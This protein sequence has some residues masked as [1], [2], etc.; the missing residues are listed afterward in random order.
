MDRLHIAVKHNVQRMTWN[1]EVNQ[2]VSIKQEVFKWMHRN[3]RPRANVNISMMYRMGN[4]IERR[5][6]KS[7][8]YP[9]KVKARPKD[10]KRKH[11]SKAL[12]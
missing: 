5:P 7:S 8:M 2:K 10:K 1:Y 6:V 4:A 9:V 12:F 3:T 11:G